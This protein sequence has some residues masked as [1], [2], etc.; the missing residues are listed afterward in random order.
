MLDEVFEHFLWW[1]FELLKE[2]FFVNVRST[3]AGAERVEFRE[4]VVRRRL[5]LYLKQPPLNPLYGN[6]DAMNMKLV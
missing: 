3:P 6:A 1:I 4:H 5:R 2:E